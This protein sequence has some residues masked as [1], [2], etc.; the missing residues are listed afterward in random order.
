MGPPHRSFGVQTMSQSGQ[1]G[2]DGSSAKERPIVGAFQ[3][4]ASE[5]GNWCTGFSSY[6]NRMRRLCPDEPHPDEEWIQKGV[7]L[8][9]LEQA[10]GVTTKDKQGAVSSG[11]EGSGDVA[12]A[13]SGSQP[14]MPLHSGVVASG[15]AGF[16]NLKRAASSQRVKDRH[17]RV[18][19]FHNKAVQIHAGDLFDIQV[20]AQDL[21]K[22]VEGVAPYLTATVHQATTSSSGASG[23]ATPVVTS[24]LTVGDIISP[25]LTKISRLHT[26]VDNR[27]HLQQSASR[28]SIGYNA[29]MDYKNSLPQGLR[30]YGE[31]ARVSVGFLAQDRSETEAAVRHSKA[32]QKLLN[33]G[34]G[35]RNKSAVVDTARS[36]GRDG[37]P[38]SR[39]SRRRYNKKCRD[40]YNKRKKAQRT[41]EFAS[42]TEAVVEATQTSM[43]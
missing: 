27:V 12:Q 25:L 3:D 9:S 30:C 1:P 22:I 37:N 21:T 36:L 42:Q 15:V 34:Q 2:S 23:A 19:S 6:V 28:S 40:L 16:K 5:A 4:V 26:L 43:E 29:F 35:R 10:Q 8:L 24:P 39:A 38:R 13:P 31:H 41:N 33:A 11:G 32:R 7:S 20:S 18:Q 14:A 17:F